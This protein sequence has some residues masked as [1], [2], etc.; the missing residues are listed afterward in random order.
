M[1][2][3]R[4]AANAVGLRP[5]RTFLPAPF[6]FAAAT[7]TRFFSITATRLNT[8][9]PKSSTSADPLPSTLWAPWQ[10]SDLKKKE[11]RFYKKY[12]PNYIDHVE[13]ETQELL[14]KGIES[15]KRVE[16][17]VKEELGDENSHLWYEVLVESSK[18]F[19][20]SMYLV[21][22]K[23]RRRQKKLGPVIEGQETPEQRQLAADREEHERADYRSK[24]REI[25]SQVVEELLKKS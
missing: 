24:R 25:R 4:R 8:A 12:G 19:R 1:L 18:R 9:D 11:I 14:R 17:I 2:L 6:T 3:L 15:R 5:A 16:A 13:A 21:H 7:T 22:E 20:K 23:F 10:V